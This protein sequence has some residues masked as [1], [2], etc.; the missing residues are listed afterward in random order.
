MRPKKVS[1][2]KKHFFDLLYEKVLNH[3]DPGSVIQP[4][5]KKIE[6]GSGSKSR[7]DPLP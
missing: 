5:L 2:I 3:R 6:K 4:A 7:F 1:I